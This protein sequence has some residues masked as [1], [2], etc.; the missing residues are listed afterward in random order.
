MTLCNTYTQRSSLMSYDIQPVNSMAF[1]YVLRSSLSYKK[2][3][4]QQMLYLSKG[5]ERYSLKTIYVQIIN[6]LPSDWLGMSS[7]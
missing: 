5:L 3:R 7:S 4:Q 2:I 1:K 6:Q